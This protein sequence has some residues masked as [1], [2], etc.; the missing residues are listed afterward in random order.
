M[1]MW[2]VKRQW[3][4][5]VSWDILYCFP[6]KEFAKQ[7]SKRLSKENP[8]RFYAVEKVPFFLHYDEFLESE[9]K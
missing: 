1:N 3:P 5:G 7:C 8:D 2:I 9:G 4:N 6:E